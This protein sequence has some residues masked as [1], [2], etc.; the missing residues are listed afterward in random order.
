MFANRD[1]IKRGFM[2]AIGK[3]ED[4]KIILNAAGWM[5]KGV[6]TESDLAEIQNA[7]D[8]YR[9]MHSEPTVVYDLPPQETG[10]P[11]GTIVPENP[12]EDVQ[13]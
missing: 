2:N 7:L 11:V 5:D 13:E 6:L 4:Y 10:E 9:T 1:F 3:M 8:A 12:T